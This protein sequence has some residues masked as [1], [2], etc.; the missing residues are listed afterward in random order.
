M[1]WWSPRLWNLVRERF[2]CGEPLLDA[3]GLDEASMGNRRDTFNDPEYW[4]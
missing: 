1:V 3:A 2:V 4:D